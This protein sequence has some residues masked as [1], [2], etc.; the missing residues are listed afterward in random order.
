MAP[1]SQTSAL[2][3]CGLP[4]FLKTKREKKKQRMT[5][6]MEK[7]DGANQRL[8]GHLGQ[9]KL[10][11]LKTDQTVNKVT[12]APCGPPFFT[13]VFVHYRLGNT[14]ELPPSV[15]PDRTKE[16]RNQ[17]RVTSARRS[18]TGCFGLCH[19][20]WKLTPV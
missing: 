16:P 4:L 12:D 18:C 20:T 13:P 17:N 1:A 3:A 8:G 10:E 19:H 6:N 11:N 9:I 2:K 5:R 7:K 15:W 14:E